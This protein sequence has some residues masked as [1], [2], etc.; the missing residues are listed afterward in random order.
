MA[1][2]C[3]L[4]GVA[5]MILP[6]RSLIK[7]AGL[8]DDLRAGKDVIARW[9]VPF[10]DLLAFVELDAQRASQGTDFHNRLRIRNREPGEGISIT[11]GRKGWLIGDRLY[12]C[13]PRSFGVFANVFGFEGD[14]GYIEIA[15]LEMREDRRWYLALARIPVPVTARKDARRVIASLSAELRRSDHLTFRDLFPEYIC[16]VDDYLRDSKAG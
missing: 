7:D 4:A 6:I 8:S 16:G 11:I 1:Q 14:P 15:A 5:L 2:L 3:L 9:Q 10:A 12:R 13:G